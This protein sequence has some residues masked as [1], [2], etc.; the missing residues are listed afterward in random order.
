M[1]LRRLLAVAVLAS[2]MLACYDAPNAPPGALLGRWGGLRAELISGP[3]EVSVRFGCGGFIGTG[4]L[5]PDPAGRFVHAVRARSN[6]SS[7]VATLVGSVAGDLITFDAVTTTT[8]GST[9]G[10]FIVTRNA[11]ADFSAVICAAPGL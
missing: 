3:T 5:V 9:T 4:A 2:F 6:P 7:A 11:Q 8:S 10:R 1:R